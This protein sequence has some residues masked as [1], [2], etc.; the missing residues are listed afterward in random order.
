MY[1]AFPDWIPTTRTVRAQDRPQAC[2]PLLSGSSLLAQCRTAIYK[3]IFFVLDNNMNP[4]TFGNIIGNWLDWKR[5]VL[6]VIL[7]SE[8]ILMTW[9]SSNE[10]TTM[11][12]VQMANGFQ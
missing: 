7:P 6:F 3:A 11:G 1:P 2:L 10:G 9:N 8:G 12:S 5:G 4:K